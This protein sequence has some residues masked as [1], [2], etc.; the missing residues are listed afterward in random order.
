LNLDE[1]NSR[2]STTENEKIPLQTKQDK[3]FE[4]KLDE[5]IYEVRIRLRSFSFD[6]LE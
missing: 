1:R 6:F 3:D 4:I 5:N 2:S